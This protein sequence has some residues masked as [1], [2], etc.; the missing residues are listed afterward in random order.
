MWALPSPAVAQL[1]GDTASVAARN[2]RSVFERARSGTEFRLSLVTGGRIEGRFARLDDG[3]A[4]FNDS[5]IIRLTDVTGVW[6][7]SSYWARGGVVGGFIGL[8]PGAVFG[9]IAGA[10]CE[11]NCSSAGKYI[12]SG[13]VAGAAAGALLGAGIGF[14]VPRWRLRYP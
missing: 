8:V 1:G 2:I 4:I 7:R 12:A 5:Q 14:L 10:A 3:H 6:Q 11:T 9:L 13:T